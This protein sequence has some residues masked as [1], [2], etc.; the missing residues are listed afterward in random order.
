M[1][2]EFA[3][4]REFVRQRI[5]ENPGLTCPEMAGAFYAFVNIKQHLGRNYGG[6]R[7][8]NS[9]QW[10]LALL[11]QQNVATVMGSAF[12]AEG[13]AR[14]SFATSLERSRRAST[15]SR[16][17][18]RGIRGQFQRLDRYARFGRLR[19][20]CARADLCSQKDRKC[21]SNPPAALRC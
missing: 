16:R 15:A 1:L 13:Y 18:W 20:R 19:M 12:G 7:V 6:T 4:R 10:C 3:K 11:E 5:A 2:A 17:F 21:L 9:T 8:D 14:I